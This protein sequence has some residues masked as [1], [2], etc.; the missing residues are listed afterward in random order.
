LLV[1]EDTPWPAI[2]RAQLS[3]G[4][5]ARGRNRRLQLMPWTLVVSPNAKI[6]ISPPKKRFQ[7]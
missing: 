5:L 1:G 2:E 3:V 4:S 7:V 6:V